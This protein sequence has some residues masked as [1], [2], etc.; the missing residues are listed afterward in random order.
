MDIDLLF[1]L[2]AGIAVLISLWVSFTLGKRLTKRL[3]KYALTRKAVSRRRKYTSNIVQEEQVGITNIDMSPII[4]D[5]TDIEEAKEIL[6]STSEGR[7]ELVLGPFLLDQWDRSYALLTIDLR[8]Q[9]QKGIETHLA[10]APWSRTHLKQEKAIV[11]MKR[12]KR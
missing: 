5:V 6:K 12:R 10:Y 1:S 4:T 7:V 11:P 8:A 2:I 9:I 3:E